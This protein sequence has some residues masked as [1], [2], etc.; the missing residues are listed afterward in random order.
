MLCLFRFIISLFKLR[1]NGL[2]WSHLNLLYICLI[3][4]LSTAPV[5][6]VNTFG[7]PSSL[8][9]YYPFSRITVE[10]LD[11]SP[12]FIYSFPCFSYIIV[13][14]LEHD[15]V[16]ILVDSIQTNTYVLILALIL[17]FFFG[18]LLS[19]AD[20]NTP[21]PVL[22]PRWG[23]KQIRTNTHT[24]TFIYNGLLSDTICQIHSKFAQRQK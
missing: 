15:F 16:G 12:V 1:F 17:S 7:T 22:K 24:H 11:E 21:S 6:D 10:S 14:I 23:Q 9:D 19:N 5:F 3:V 8:R 20:L 18:V 13:V 4:K 2:V